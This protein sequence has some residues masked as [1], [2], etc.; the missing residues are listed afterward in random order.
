MAYTNIH[1]IKVTLGKSINYICKFEKTGNGKYISSVNCQYNTAEYEFEFTRKEMNDN[2][3]NLAYHSYQSFK[4]GEVTPEQAHEIGMQTMKEFLKGEYEFVLTTHIDKNHIHNHIIINSV[5]MINGK[6]F[7][8]E[9]DRKYAPA[10]KELRT[11]SDKICAERGLSV[12]QTD[13]GKGMSHYEW[14][15]NKAGIS[16]KQQLKNI[17]DETIKQSDNFEDFLSKLCAKN[18]EVK[19]QDYKKKSGKCLG[20]K[21]PGQKYFIYSQNLGWYYEEKQLNKRIDIAVERRNE[22]KSEA[23][24]RRFMNQDNRLKEFFDLS[25]ERFSAGGL[26]R[27]ARMQNLKIGFKTISVLH[28]YGFKDAEDFLNKYDSLTDEK[29]QNEENIQSLTKKIN[30][31]KYRL[32]YLKI[33]RKY[34][35]INEAYKKAVFQDRYF[36]NHEDEL[37]L[38]QEAVEELKKTEKTR[39][40][41]NAG[42]LAADIKSLEEEKNKLL[43]GNKTIDKKLKEYDVLKNNLAKMLLDEPENK[44]ENVQKLQQKQVQRNKEDIQI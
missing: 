23:R 16:W 18:I 2:M 38:F 3:K 20:F 29:L 43:S 39:E 40:L 1:P 9:H 7:S 21:M 14:E 31:N 37:L 11:I 42:K 22:T 34:K 5:N 4:K 35:P 15:Q 13:K 17:I 6:S 33:Y 19:Y 30:F 26:N 12:I 25:D 32:K 44:L 36:R 41:P 10:W 27:W 8:R 24:T 28:E